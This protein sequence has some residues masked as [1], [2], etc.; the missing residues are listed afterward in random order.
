MGMPF[1][2]ADAP[3][4]NP[5]VGEAFGGLEQL[6]RLS[7]GQQW[8]IGE[9]HSGRR[10]FSCRK[11]GRRCGLVKAS[12]LRAAAPPAPDALRRAAWV[13]VRSAVPIGRPALDGSH[14]LTAQ[15]YGLSLPPPGA[16]VRRC[17]V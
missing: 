12:A 3:F 7:D 4:G 8:V 14:R 11:I 10:P 16:E 1:D 15:P 9:A 13:P 2:E 6:G 17:G 5:P